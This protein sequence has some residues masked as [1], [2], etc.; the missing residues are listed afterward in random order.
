MHEHEERPLYV[1][2]AGTVKVSGASEA[3]RVA[4]YV[5]L[6][7]SQGTRD[8]ELLFIGANAG[9]Q[10]FKA[11]NIVTEMMLRHQGVALSFTCHRFI[12]DASKRTALG[13]PVEGGALEKRDAF[14]WRVVAQ[15]NSCTPAPQV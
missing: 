13:V 1:E 7:L 5:A 8:V 9:Q 12:T 3:V 2:H 15:K 14:V 11:C 4:K 6:L 10:A